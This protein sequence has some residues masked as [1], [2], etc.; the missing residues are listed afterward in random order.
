MA[1]I[2]ITFNADLGDVNQKG[3]VRPE[4]LGALFSM[5]YPN[6]AGILNI[7]G[8]DCS[9]FGSINVVGSTAQVTFH[10]GY[11]VVFGRAIYIEEGTQVAFNLPASGTTN[12]VLGVKINLAENAENEVTWFQKVGTPQ[13]DDLAKNPATGVYEFVLYYYTATASTLSLTAKTNELI[14]NVPVKITDM[15]TTEKFEQSSK[16]LTLKL[17]KQKGSSIVHG[18]LI[19]HIPTKGKNGVVTSYT[20]NLPEEFRPARDVNIFAYTGGTG[21]TELTSKEQILYFGMTSALNV[22]FVFVA[23]AQ[24]IRASGSL[25]FQLAGIR[26]SDNTDLLTSPI[27][28]SFTYSTE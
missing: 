6:S 18:T 2:P 25:T 20:Y 19:G 8:Q 21:T 9:Q 17:Y 3:N 22:V 5:L 1:L 7:T 11:I 15:M 12:G 27:S 26:G 23:Q 13:T 4:D 24:P 16:D 14:D 10:S 28:Y